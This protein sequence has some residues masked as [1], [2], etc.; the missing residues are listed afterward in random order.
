MNSKTEDQLLALFQSLARN[1]SSWNNERD[2]PRSVQAKDEADVM[3]AI[4]MQ[5]SQFEKLSS[6]V[7]K[8]SSSNSLQPV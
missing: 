8:I 4:S 7:Q 1:F 2:K 6:D 5:S 3:K